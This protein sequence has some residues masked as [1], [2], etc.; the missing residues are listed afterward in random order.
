MENS[1]LLLIWV[2]LFKTR[3]VVLCGGGEISIIEWDAVDVF[4]VVLASVSVFSECLVSFPMLLAINRT[5]FYYSLNSLSTV[6]L[7]TTH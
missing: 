3:D 6:Q 7:C 5:T 2:S 1:Y 4:L